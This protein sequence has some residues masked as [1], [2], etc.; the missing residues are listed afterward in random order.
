MAPAGRRPQPRGATSQVVRFE[1]VF[2]RYDG[3]PVILR[4]V[5]FELE[6]GSFQFLTGGSGAGKS[7]L[8]KLMARLYDPDRGA[9]RFGGLDLRRATLSSLRE[10]I[11]V[12]P[13]EGFLFDG[14][15]ADNL[16]LARP[17]ASDDEIRGALAAFGGVRDAFVTKLDPAGGLAYSSFLGGYYQDVAASIAL[18]W[19]ELFQSLVVVAWQDAQACEPT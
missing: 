17:G 8:A 10:R 6:P 4:D 9:V 7:S 2:M 19:S 5:S 1:N 13:Q 3:G 16:R 15:T 14:T 11:V 18:A 12:V